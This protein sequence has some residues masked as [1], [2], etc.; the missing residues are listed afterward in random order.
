MTLIKLSPLK[1]I[2]IL[3]CM[4][5]LLAC[6]TPP[7]KTD[8][9]QAV[10][11]VELEEGKSVT[12]QT[13][14]LSGMINLS[15]EI[16]TIQPCSSS[17]QYWLEVTETQWQHI[18]PLIK[19]V[20]LPL[21][22]EVTG[23][24]KEP[25][26][27]GFSSDFPARFTVTHINQITTDNNQACTTAYSPTKAFGNEPF[28]A[29]KIKNQQLSYGQPAKKTETESISKQQLKHRSREYYSDSFSLSMQKEYCTDTM[30]NALYGWS[31]QITTKSKTLSGCGAISNRDTTQLWSGEYQAVT[32]QGLAITLTLHNDHTATT[33]YH[34]KKE[35][36]DTKETGV[37][38]QINS[39][40]IHVLMSRHQRLYMISERVFTRNGASISAENEKVNGQLYGLGPNGITLFKNN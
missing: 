1:I 27:G 11:N 23:Y 38:Q 15:S 37:W 19:N 8:E 29:V 21:Y 24:F 39:D 13:L 35:D 3:F 36:S 7:S 30:S 18:A 2:T 9:P 40:Q 14:M 16:Q 25:H 26:K 22:A 17:V 4:V 28:W 20:N 32:P 34:S 33:L 10:L 31:S 5:S 6:S 12:P